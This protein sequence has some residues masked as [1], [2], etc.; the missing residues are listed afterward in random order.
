MFV[1]FMFV[2]RF[3]AFSFVYELCVGWL[4][5]FLF[6]FLVGVC[7]FASC[8]TGL[9]GFGFVVSVCLMLD[10]FL[11]WL[12][13]FGTS[14]LCWVGCF[15]LLV[16]IGVLLI[17]LNRWVYINSN[18]SLFLMLIYVLLSL[19]YMFRVLWDVV[20]LLCYGFFRCL[21]WTGLL[22]VWLRYVWLG[23]VVGWVYTL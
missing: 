1:H 6:S 5:Y 23:V 9:P 12:V 14:C 10:C 11:L 16:W 20:V 15:V 4:F 22:L 19:L 7:R 2:C 8:I 21:L 17:C 13:L 3:V 18:R